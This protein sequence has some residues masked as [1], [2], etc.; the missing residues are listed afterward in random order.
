MF[1]QDLPYRLMD[2]SMADSGSKRKDIALQER[3][4][5]VT[6]LLQDVG[7]MLRQS[8]DTMDG[9]WEDEV[10]WRTERDRQFNELRA[11]LAGIVKRDETHARIPSTSGTTTEIIQ[12]IDRAKEEL[13]SAVASRAEE[14]SELKAKMQEE[15]TELLHNRGR[16]K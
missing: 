4:S 8:R 14:M 3:L 15:L 2:E 5:D 10:F 12:D 1:F 13:A 9:R 16:P 11:S 7:L 6:A